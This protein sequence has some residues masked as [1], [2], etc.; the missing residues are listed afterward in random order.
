MT[1]F[2]TYLCVCTRE[3]GVLLC[4]CTRER[5]VLLCV[6][7]RE[8]GVLLCVCM[9]ERGVLLCVYMCER[10][11]LLCVC[12]RE[13][14]VLLCAFT[15]SSGCW[16][17]CGEVPSEPPCSEPS[18]PGPPCP[19]PTTS[20]GTQTTP[21]GLHPPQKSLLPL[22]RY[23]VPH[24]TSE[25]EKEEEVHCEWWGGGEGVWSSR[26]LGGACEGAHQP[27]GDGGR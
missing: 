7:T 26:A 17:M 6:C 21:S 19:C 9:C 25:G 5:G 27:A 16:F 3:R 4:V 2:Y 13:R 1:T 11:V 24:L 8:R 18:S 20:T 22:P 23:T 15:F 12:T 10:G 14:G